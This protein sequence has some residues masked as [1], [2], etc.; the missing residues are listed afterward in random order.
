MSTKISIRLPD[1]V[2]QELQGQAE[3]EKRTVSQVIILRLRGHLIRRPAL[4][5]KISLARQAKSGPSWDAI[6][7][8]ERDG[9]DQEVLNASIGVMARKA[10]KLEPQRFAVAGLSSHDPKTCR[11]YRCGMCATLKEK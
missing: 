2:L 11:I 5:E 10:D 6:I 7:E 8:R 3:Q 4:D 1:D 9:T